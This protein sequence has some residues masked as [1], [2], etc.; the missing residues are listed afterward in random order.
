[1]TASPAST[2]TRRSRSFRS[3]ATRARTVLRQHRAGV[4]KQKVFDVVIGAATF[5]QDLAQ[6]VLHRKQDLDAT[7]PGTDHADT[8]AIVTRQDAVGHRLPV[9]DELID[10]LHRHDVSGRARNVGGSR[11][12]ADVERDD[13]ISHRRPVAALNGLA[14]QIDADRFIMKEP[15]T[16]EPAERT[17]VD[18]RL[19]VVVGAVIALSP[20]ATGALSN[21]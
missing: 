14:D 20:K 10:R 4:A 9:R 8:H 17:E 7:G 6:P 21:Y 13:V 11:R 2:R 18:M 5:A 19:V 3:K 1:M 12:R 15:S 16:R